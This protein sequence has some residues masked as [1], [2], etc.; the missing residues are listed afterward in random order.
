MLSP[1]TRGYGSW[2]GAHYDPYSDHAT[3]EKLPQINEREIHRHGVTIG[4]MSRCSTSLSFKSNIA[5][6]ATPIS[7]SEKLQRETTHNRLPREITSVDQTNKYDLPKTYLTKKGALML[8]TA[9]KE[10]QELDE[11]NGNPKKVKM[12]RVKKLLD[13]TLQ[14]GSLD[15]LAMSILQYGDEEEYDKEN[16]SISDEKHKLFMKILRKA[17]NQRELDTRSQPGSDLHSY[18]RDLKFRARASMSGDTNIPRS[19]EAMELRAILQG[20]QDDRWPIV[21]NTE[22]GTYE[23]RSNFGDQFTRPASQQSHRPQTSPGSG[24]ATPRSILSASKLRA[25]LKSYNTYMGRP[26]TDETAREIRSSLPTVGMRHSSAPSIGSRPLDIMSPG[27]GRRRTQSSVT[28]GSIAEEEGGFLPLYYDPLSGMEGSSIVYTDSTDLGQHMYTFDLASG[29]SSLFDVGSHGDG[30]KPLGEGSVDMVEEPEKESD[31]EM[32]NVVG[33]GSTEVASEPQSSSNHIQV[34]VEDHDTNTC[35]YSTQYDFE[36]DCVKGGGDGVPSSTIGGGLSTNSL[37]DISSAISSQHDPLS[38]TEKLDVETS[39]TISEDLIEPPGVNKVDIKT[40]AGVIPEEESVELG[41]DGEGVHIPQGIDEVDE[42]ELDWEEKGEEAACTEVDL[43]RYG[44][45]GEEDNGEGDDVEESTDEIRVSPKPDSAQGKSP[46][47]SPAQPTKTHDPTS[48]PKQ[49]PDSSQI[50]ASLSRPGSRASSKSTSPQIPR[51]PSPSKQLSSISQSNKKSPSPVQKTV[52][53]SQKPDPDKSSSVEVIKPCPS[54]E[55]RGKNTPPSV[56]ITKKQ[57]QIQNNLL[58]FD[59]KKDTVTSPSHTVGS[60]SQVSTEKSQSNQEHTD[61]KS[62]KSEEVLP[63]VPFSSSDQK[64]QGAPDAQQSQIMDGGAPAQTSVTSA[65]EK[66]EKSKQEDENEES[67]ESSVTSAEDKSKKKQLQSNDEQK[68]YSEIESTSKTEPEAPTRLIDQMPVIPDYLKPKPQKTPKTKE[69]KTKKQQPPR[70][71][72]DV[73]KAMSV[74]SIQPEAE[75]TG[76]EKSAPKVWEHEKVDIPPEKEELVIPDHMKEAFS[77]DTEQSKTAL[78]EQMKQMA[79]ILDDTFKV[80]IDEELLEVGLTEEEL[81]EAKME[82]EEKLNVAQAKINEMEKTGGADLESEET[83][84]AEKEKAVKL[85]EGK[86]K[87]KGGKGGKSTPKDTVAKVQGKSDKELEKQKVL[88]KEQKRTEEKKK[89]EEKRKLEDQI[90]ERQELV[91]EHEQRTRDKELEL[92]L[93]VDRLRREELEMQ[94]AVDE[95]HKYLAESRK[96]QREERDQRRKADQERRR[97][98]AREKF[99]QDKKKR[100]EDSRK[101]MDEL[102]R[103][104]DLEMRKQKKLEEEMRREEEERLAIEQAEEE[105]NSRVKAAED[106]ER[107]LREIELQMEE[108]EMQR[109]YLQ[110]QEISRQRI[111]LEM[112]REKMSEEEELKRQELLAEQIKLEEIKRKKEEEEQRVLDEQRRRLM[113]LKEMEEAAKLKM[114]QDLEERRAKALARREENLENKSNMDKLKQSQGITKAWVFSYFVRWPLES[115]MVPIGGD[116]TKKKGFR[117]KTNRPKTAK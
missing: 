105:E 8:F 69:K 41:F 60:L 77:R 29:E 64:E 103:I 73:T 16:T 88:K 113:E 54:P 7:R 23:N 110:E 35:D 20:L 90:Q 82:V 101:V 67:H 97:E 66:E 24:T 39:T 17:E 102:D 116:E 63:S 28:G 12:H 78:E 18:L 56:T 98:H 93:E 59:A 5:P 87:K 104:H 9:P 75:V 30:I 89:L 33:Q 3:E 48:P 22:S 80:T 108:E 84:R 43:A 111:L 42:G 45:I 109:L 57:S 85:K 40:I 99:E 49:E 51:T 46:A 96:R 37:V 27:K 38:E 32:S 107:R 11:A 55:I 65:I 79:N 72:K 50:K 25:S 74:A 47:P 58:S 92:K 36:V 2:D 106:Q 62:V 83:Q 52:S 68:E 81:L 1:L 26:A 117:P 15:R 21:Y 100:E 34:V 112:E 61:I 114:Q 14:M 95:V 44:I 91:E 86:A 70:S 31:V 13:S 19:R 76:K 6:P 71:K 10:E 115:Y 53:P 94:E 4:H